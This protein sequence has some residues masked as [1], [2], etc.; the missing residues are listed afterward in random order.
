MFFRTHPD[1]NED[2]EESSE[3]SNEVN[4]EDRQESATCS[5]G[6]LRTPTAKS[7]APRHA[8][9]HTPPSLLAG[10]QKPSRLL[11]LGGS[12]TDMSYLMPCLPWAQSRT[13]PGD[14]DIDS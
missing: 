9:S 3:E 14:P 12:S 13:A 10:R 4:A 5:P 6:S 11:R 1:K 7:H 8:R 2:S